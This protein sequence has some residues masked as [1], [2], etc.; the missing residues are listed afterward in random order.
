MRYENTFK[1]LTNLIKTHNTKRRGKNHL[2]E[3]ARK[4]T[5]GLYLLANDTDKG[6]QMNLPWEG[7]PKFWYHNQEGPFMD[8][9]PSRFRWWGNQSRPITDGWSIQIGLYG[10]KRFL[11]CIWPLRTLK[12]DS[13]TLNWAWKQM[14][15][16]NI[17][18]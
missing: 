16:R 17:W 11:R 15:R 12:D 6:R 18:T 4:E 10:R 3:Y 9:H 13:S 7:V 8:H 5:K 2:G 14:G 1:L